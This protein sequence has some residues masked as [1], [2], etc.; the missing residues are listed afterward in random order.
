MTFDIQDYCR[1]FTKEM[2]DVFGSRVCYIGLQGS[3]LRGEATE[4]S[5]IDMMVVLDG[6]T[7]AD[8]D[9]YRDILH[10]VGDA[11]RSCGFICALADLARWNPLELCQL[12]YTTKDI[13]GTLAALLPPWTVENEIHYIQLSLDNLYHGLCHSYIHGNRDQLAENLLPFYKSAFFILQNT[14]FLEH[15][16]ADPHHAAFACTRLELTERLS[17]EDRAV[18]EALLSLTSG[19]QPEVEA[20]FGRL[21]QWCQHKMAQVL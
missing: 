14:D 9:Q 18:M 11:D 16:R 17:G 2:L 15:F 10:R 3:Y 6:L 7:V 13:H 1:R 5:D 21:F 4:H 12:V 8:M 19:R 20:D